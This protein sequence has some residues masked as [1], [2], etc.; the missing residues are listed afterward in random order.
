MFMKIAG[1]PSP[2]SGFPGRPGLRLGVYALCVA[3]TFLCL[4]LACGQSVSDALKAAQ[5]GD[6]IEVPAG[7]HTVSLNVPEGVTLRG[8]PGAVIDAT[9]KRDGIHV[10][11]RDGGRKAT[12]DGLEIIG[13]DYGV[14]VIKGATEVAIKN[15]TI[16]D[17]KFGVWIRDS[18]NVDVSNCEISGNR[19]GVAF[20]NSG[21]GKVA[22]CNIHHNEIDGVLVTFQSHDIRIS[23]NSIHHHTAKA[24]PD[25]IQ[26]HNH[27]ERL[28]I[29]GNLIYENGQA[30]HSQQTEHVLIQNNVI[31]GTLAQALVVGKGDTT[32]VEIR[33][34][35]IAYTG[36]IAV[37]LTA[38]H[39]EFFDNTVVTGGGKG[40]LNY[41]NAKDVSADRNL[42][43][44]TDRQKSTLLLINDRG[45]YSDFQKYRA[46]TTLD[47]NS[48]SRN[49]M[50][51]S[52]PIASST[53]DT[54]RLMVAE[55]FRIPVARSHVF[56]EGDV[57]EIGFDGVPRR[58]QSVA[59]DSIVFEPPLRKTPAHGATVLI[60]GHSIGEWNL[61]R[62]YRDLVA[63]LNAKK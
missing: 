8:L 14:Q 61:G 58:V 48:V 10:I 45:F 49:P 62:K 44:G 29:T 2:R 24:H 20:Y 33:D 11:G 26:T 27:V 37:N 19:N 23:G 5:P 32:N 59:D 25:A 57:I 36:H 42:Y 50:F 18:S 15:C 40:A 9:G 6:V 47:Q 63:K 31:L 13:A 54:E 38:A 55:T 12:I 43:W 30:L 35:L 56:H 28:N 4:P 39:Y 46:Q 3:W 60:W 7:L 41:Q 52:A 1:A 22:D 16:R 17:C 34:N 53:I 51:P 21:P